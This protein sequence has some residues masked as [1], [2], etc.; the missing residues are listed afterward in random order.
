M[1]RLN[2]AFLFLVATA[3][4]A[5]G[6]TAVSLGRDISAVDTA[7]VVGDRVEISISDAAVD[8]DVL[9]VS[10]LVH[11]PTRYRITYRS[12]FVRVFNETEPQLAYGSARRVDDGGT[13]VP[14]RGELAVSLRVRLSPGQA[15]RLAA[16]MAGDDV[17]MAVTLGLG[18]RDTRFTAVATDDLQGDGR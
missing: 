14:P 2:L 17:S 5:G 6:A 18:Y 4:A 11:N 8:G 7:V 13:T 12:A 10:A 3:A 9:A 1:N 15:D 16:A